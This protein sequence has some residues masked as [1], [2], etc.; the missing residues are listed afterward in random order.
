M[1][2]SVVL[3]IALCVASLSITSCNRDN[4]RNCEEHQKAACNEDPNKTNIRIVNESQFDFCNVV[5]NP[6]GGD[7]NYGIIEKG[8]ATCYRSFDV[9]YDYAAVTLDIGGRTFTLEPI[10]FTGEPTLGNG[11]FTYTLDV[12]NFNNRTLSITTTKN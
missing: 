6:S 10:D 5:L 1:K 9:A 8:T 2:L 7:V 3:G 4:L 12:L 11:N